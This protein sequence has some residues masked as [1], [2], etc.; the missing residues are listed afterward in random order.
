ME[1]NWRGHLHKPLPAGTGVAPHVSWWGN[2][3]PSQSPTGL[4]LEAAWG[5]Q[6]SDM[7]MLLCRQQLMR[8]LSDPDPPMNTLTCT[9]GSPGS[10]GGGGLQLSFRAEQ[11]QWAPAW[12]A[13]ELH[14]KSHFSKERETGPNQNLDGATIP[15]Q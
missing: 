5:V 3:H 4:G 12:A 15:H 9:S 7:N 1:S 8:S 6:V 14:E 13:F 10:K 2:T 11:G